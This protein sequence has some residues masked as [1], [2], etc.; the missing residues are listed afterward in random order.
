MKAIA[1]RP[2]QQPP[3]SADNPG[4]LDK[5]IDLSLTTISTAS[6]VVAD[7]ASSSSTNL[8]AQPVSKNESTLPLVDL[9]PGLKHHHRRIQHHSDL[10]QNLL[11]EI[12]SL[13]YDIDHGTRDRMHSGILDIHWNEWTAH[14]R[15]HGFE[16][17]E[18]ILEQHADVVCCMICRLEE[19]CSANMIE[20]SILDGQVIL[21]TCSISDHPQSCC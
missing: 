4:S 15:R 13:Q 17:F 21:R 6:T 11:A 16:H 2:V 7:N 12:K 10:V 9:P 19:S 8:N 18:K 20:G 1:E 14:R 5:E 3:N